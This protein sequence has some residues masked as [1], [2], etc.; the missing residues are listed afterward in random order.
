MAVPFCTACGAS[1]AEGTRFCIKCGQPI[2]EGSPTGA[3]QATAFMTASPPPPMEQP[4]W[5][6]P[7]PPAPMAAPMVPPPAS[8]GAGAGVWIGIF[9]LL[10]LFGGAGFW[11]Y[12]SRMARVHPPGEVQVATAPS[13]PVVDPPEPSPGVPTPPTPAPEVAPPSPD[14]AKPDLAKKDPPPKQVAPPKPMAQAR[15]ADS[16][17]PPQP[18]VTQPAVTQPVVPQPAVAQ[19][20]RPARQTSGVLHA[21]VEVGLNGEVVFENLPAARLRFTFDHSLWQPTISHQPNGTQTLVMRSLKR[22][23]QTSCDVTWE[24]VQ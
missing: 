6:P 7:P 16:V 24:M 12:A 10:L 2:G 23:I 15:P 3:D 8:G 4:V 21:T 13:T 14:I 1:V 19:P 5:L 20:L 9:A 11:F 22:G 18:V 17:P